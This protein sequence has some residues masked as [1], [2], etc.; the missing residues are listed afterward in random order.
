[1][2]SKC[3]Q[4][5]GVDDLKVFK[6]Y[7]LCYIAH[8]YEKMHVCL[9]GR[10][11][12]VR[13]LVS[14]SKNADISSHPNF[15]NIEELRHNK[16]VQES[17]NYLT[18]GSPRTQSPNVTQRERIKNDTEPTPI[19]YFRSTNDDPKSIL[20]NLTAAQIEPCQSSSFV[21]KAIQ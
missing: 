6:A 11:I 8:Y 10:R 9:E 3:K 4:N 13:L 7:N 20:V 17:V 2:D 19:A 18:Y 1:M 5:I 12:K 16:N 21:I 14:L 15:S